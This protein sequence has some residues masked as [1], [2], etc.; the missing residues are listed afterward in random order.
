M[1]K[2]ENLQKLFKER[3]AKKLPRFMT[4]GSNIIVPDYCIN[5]DIS[6]TINV[7]SPI[8][9]SL[10]S[11]IKTQWKDA[12]TNMKIKLRDSNLTGEALRIFARNEVNE[13]KMLRYRLFCLDE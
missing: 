2:K 4:N 3:D 7:D 13:L 11:K 12:Y 1:Q 10:H 8:P 9:T 6:L 5:E